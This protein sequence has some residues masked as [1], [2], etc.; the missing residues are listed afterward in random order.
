M[1]CIFMTSGTFD[2]M[3]DGKAEHRR[4]VRLSPASRIMTLKNQCM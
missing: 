4:A 3:Y 2:A 1:I